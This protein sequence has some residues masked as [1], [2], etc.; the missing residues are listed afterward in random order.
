M[1]KFSQFVMAA[2]C[3]FSLANGGIVEGMNAN[4]INALNVVRTLYVNQTLRMYRDNSIQLPQILHD[5]GVTAKYK[6]T[7]NSI[8]I[9]KSGL[10]KAISNANGNPFTVYIYLK[11]FKMDNQGNFSF[12]LNKLFYAQNGSPML[13]LNAN[14]NNVHIK[15]NFSK[16]D[17]QNRVIALRQRLAQGVNTA[18]VVPTVTLNYFHGNHNNTFLPIMGNGGNVHFESITPVNLGA[19]QQLDFTVQNTQGVVGNVNAANGWNLQIANA[20]L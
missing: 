15:L 18:T 10:F 12:D 17:V 1:K 20:N 14:M 5:N 6:A 2:A 16:L 4:Q 9:K 8:V 3:V 19:G 11:A 7:N 13:P